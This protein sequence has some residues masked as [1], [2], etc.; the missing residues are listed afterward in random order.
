MADAGVLAAQ[1][2]RAGAQ[3][4]A[5]L[6]EAG[7]PAA[8]AHVPRLLARG[9]EVQVGVVRVGRHRVLR[10]DEL[11]GAHVAQVARGVGEPA[12]AALVQREIGEVAD[13]R[14]AL[15][16]R[17]GQLERAERGVGGERVRVSAGDQRG[18]S[19][20]CFVRG[21]KVMFVRDPSA[22][23]STVRPSSPA[24]S[25]CASPLAGCQSRSSTPIA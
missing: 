14:R 4:V 7:D 20:N 15:G 17:L 18:P 24:I 25:V 2:E 16:R 23:T 22:T 13:R 19:Q 5:V 3:R 10:E 1:P 9:V 11:V 8:A 12:L 6:A 21:R